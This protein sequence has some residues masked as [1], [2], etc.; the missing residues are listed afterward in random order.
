MTAATWTDRRCAAEEEAR[1]ELREDEPAPFVVR[2]RTAPSAFGAHDAMGFRALAQLATDTALMSV[3]VDLVEGHARVA[4]HAP[5]REAPTGA[6]GATVLD[7]VETLAHDLGRP[8]VVRWIAAQRAELDR[9][10]A[11]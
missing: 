8:D 10:E 3:H 1:V 6:G 2:P 9:A 11:P 7:A 4:V 5:G